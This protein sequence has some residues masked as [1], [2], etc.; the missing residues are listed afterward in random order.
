MNNC[1]L[2]QG[3]PGAPGPQ[4]PAG[5]QGP[6]GLS[7]EAGLPGTA[8]VNGLDV[9]GSVITLGMPDSFGRI[10]SHQNLIYWT[11]HLRNGRHII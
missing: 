8:G 2:L 3:P 11:T 6:V 10:S 4:G 7:G 5:P 1:D 9:S